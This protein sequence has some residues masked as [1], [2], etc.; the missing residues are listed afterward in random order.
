[1]DTNLEYYK[2][3][4]Y[5]AKYGRFTKAAE[6]LCITQPAVS[7]AMKHL[8]QAL[9]TTLFYRT[10][11]GMK[12]TREGEELFFYVRQGYEYLVMGEEKIKEMKDLSHGEIRIGASDMTLQFYLLPYLEQFHQNYPRVKIA[13]TNGPT[14]D[15][16]NQLLSG[17]ID[18]GVIS[19][20]FAKKEE[21]AFQEVSRIEDV[22]VV[23]KRFKELTNRT[24]SYE[25]LNEL[26]VICLEENTSSRGFIDRHLLEHGV[27]LKPE[28]E[29]ATSDMIVQFVLRN[30]GV[31]IV[32]KEFVRNYLESGQ[33]FALKFKQPIPRREIG[34]IRKNKRPLSSAAQKFLETIE[35]ENISR[36]NILYKEY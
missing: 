35:K 4:Y 34:I 3:F 28:I 26:P 22:I 10:Q 33:L 6:E 19:T 14:P 7:Q 36:D 32:M 16:M 18:F 5:V 27:V 24:L 25:I 13:V 30:L 12:L 11:K 8:E 29:L 2:I 23:G 1:M 21:I 15:T 17:N 31:G 20:P 9:A